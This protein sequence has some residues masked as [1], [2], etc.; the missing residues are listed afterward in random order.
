[1]KYFSLWECNSKSYLAC[2]SQSGNPLYQYNSDYDLCFYADPNHKYTWINSYEF[3]LSIN[4][5]L[6][7]ANTDQKL[8]FARNLTQAWPYESTWV[9]KTCF[10][11]F[12]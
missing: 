6:L 2:S 12:S 8:Q 11:L 10:R 7:I 3:C 9:S 4:G 5:S 1:M